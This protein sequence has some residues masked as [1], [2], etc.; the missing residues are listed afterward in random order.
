[1]AILRTSEIR[2]MTIEE[3]ADELENLNNELVRERALTSAG[4]AP[5]NPGRIGE[6]RRTIARIKTI[7]HELN[8]I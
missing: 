7:Q 4:G 6:I 3:R 5:E 2:T 8:E 1:M